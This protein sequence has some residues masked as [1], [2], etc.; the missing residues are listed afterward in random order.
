M[1]HNEDEKKEQAASQNEPEKHAQSAPEIGQQSQPNYKE[2]FLRANADFQNFK[3]R[4]E[5][6]RA[7]W[8]LLIQTE[9]LERIVPILDEFERALNMA[10]AQVTPEH[11]GWLEGFQLIAK[12]FKKT[13][14]DL[15]VEEIPTTGFFNPELHEALMT[16]QSPDHTSGH[17]VQELRK[18]YSYKGKVLRHAQVTVAQ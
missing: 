5:R 11:A 7:E 14:T 9:I 17:I 13:L 12:N 3:R 6:E 10:Q 8:S 16:V 15:G 1:M 18:G 2:L 4:T